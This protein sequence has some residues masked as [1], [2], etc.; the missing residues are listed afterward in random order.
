[1]KNGKVAFVSDFDGTITDDDFFA[2]TTKAYFNEQALAPWKAFIAGKKSHFQALKEMFAQIRVS[3]KKLHET[4][5]S[6]FVDPYLEPTWQTCR[7][8]NVL[9]YVC[10]AG[11]DYYI[12]R[13]IGDCLEKYDVKLISNT[14]IYTTET[15]LVMIPPDKADPYYDSEVGISKRKVVEKLKEEGFFV[16]FAGDGPPDIMPAELADVVFAKKYLLKTCREKG[17]KTKKFE[18]FKDIL[19]YFKRL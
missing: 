1:M 7:E 8:K 10:S 14:G 4:I 2:Y 12:R 17:I 15:G 19:N 6:I 18:S 11:N 9:L 3:E 16:V 5:D 13:L